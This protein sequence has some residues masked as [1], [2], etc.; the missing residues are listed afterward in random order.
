MVINMMLWKTEGDKFKE[1]LKTKLD[2][3]VRLENWIESDVSILG[4]DI[5]IIGRQVRTSFGGIVDLLGIDAQGD[6]LIIELK[7]DKTPRDIVAQV[8][9]YASW[10]N[11]VTSKDINAIAE[12]YLKESLAISFSKRFGSSISE[13]INSD[14]R[15]IIVAS[16]L[17][18][19][20]ERIIQY[21]STKYSVNINAVFFIFFKDDNHEYLGRSWLINPDDVDERAE[22]RSRLPW[23][24]YWY[25][26]VAEGK[27]RSWDDC[28]KYGFL[29][30]G[31]AKVYSDYLKK[32]KKGDKIFAYQKAAGYVGYGKVVQEA[33]MVKD[34][35]PEGSEN[36]IL[37]LPLTQPG[38]SENSDEPELSEWVV[39]VK[40]MKTF[41][42]DDAKK[43]SGVFAN[44]NVVCK[45]RHQ[46]TIDFLKREFSINE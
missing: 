16:E 2:N 18:D 42:R 5:L 43:F 24:G 34:F 19:Y 3:E 41:L 40:W 46:A 11:N 28:M 33:T 35:I 12:K 26:N 29:S 9:D 8:L 25:F 4:L 13:T 39:G 32:L 7:K 44:P 23:S 36:N 6:I 10:I 38:M 27:T 37:E 15:L 14:H 21:L 20:S 17:D 1:V 30:A 31:Q 22:A 45:L